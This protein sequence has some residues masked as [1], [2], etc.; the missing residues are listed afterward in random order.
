MSVTKGIP[1]GLQRGGDVALQIPPGEPGFK[2]I[3]KPF[4]EIM[5]GEANQIIVTAFDKPCWFILQKQAVFGADR[6]E[7]AAGV[8]YTLTRE[9][10]EAGQT[11]ARFTN[12]PKWTNVEVTF[13]AAAFSLTDRPGSGP[14]HTIPPLVG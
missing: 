10:P 4:G 9:R 6:I 7:L 11:K 1:Q 12:D 13:D 8:S 2:V 5:Q 14:I 3:D